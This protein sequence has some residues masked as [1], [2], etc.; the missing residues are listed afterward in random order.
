[1]IE[2]LQSKLDEAQ[3]LTATAIRKTDKPELAQLIA[4]LALC[5]RV[6][7]EIKATNLPDNIG[8]Q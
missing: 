8:K 4:H 2:Q 7:Q 3:K 6:L 5:Q 1:M